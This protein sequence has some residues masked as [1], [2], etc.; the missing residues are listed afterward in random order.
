MKKFFVIV[1][2]ISGILNAQ[3]EYD[4]TYK[5]GLRFVHLEAS[6]F[7]ADLNRGI[8]RMGPEAK[9]DFTY[10][11]KASFFFHFRN[12]AWYDPA[13]SKYSNKQTIF[14]LAYSPSQK[15]YLNLE[16]GLAW[17]VYK[18]NFQGSV[19]FGLSNTTYLLPLYY[20]GMGKNYCAPYSIKKGINNALSDTLWTNNLTELP[21]FN[22]AAGVYGVSA[23]VKSTDVFLGWQIRTG[24]DITDK[25]FAEGDPKFSEYY[26]D[27]IYNLSTKA[28]DLVFGQTHFE[29]QF[30]KLNKFGARLGF[31]KQYNLLFGFYYGAELAIRPGYSYIPVGKSNSG[32]LNS[33]SATVKIGLKIGAPT[34]TVKKFL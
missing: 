34:K 27:I 5:Q 32:F 19:R 31:S 13:F 15:K 12:A 21:G 2:F 1:F 17:I 3:E 26:F 9:F 4:T 7:T 25:W 24:Y 14:N 16:A 18:K 11:D 30:V 10:Q 33:L 28:E 29:P 23:T 8:I 6:V 20:D 22:S